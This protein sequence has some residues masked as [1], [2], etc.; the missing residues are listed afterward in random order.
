[1]A[2]AQS[3]RLLPIIGGVV[4]LM[5]V[6][7]LLRACGGPED[8]VHLREVPQAPA[9][10]ADSPAE[11]IRTLS[12]QVADMSSTFEVLRT[13]NETLR[14]EQERRERQLDREVA[15]RVQDELARHGDAPARGLE[16]VM[17]RIDRLSGRVEDLSARPRPPAELEIPIGLGL[18]DG[19]RPDGAPRV[20]PPAVE[21]IQWVDPIGWEDNG[22][23]APGRRVLGSA[24]LPGCL[25]FHVRASRWHAPRRRSVGPCRGC[26][27][28]RPPGPSTPC[29]ATPR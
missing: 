10:D 21:R 25:P 16:G 24:R 12:A 13:E 4:A 2:F 7:V 26:S 15:R 28:T 5:A 22:S 29:R 23:A 20:R 18:E 9:P 11:T 14:R 3:N 17:E 19:E 27:R 8:S 6:F 1:M